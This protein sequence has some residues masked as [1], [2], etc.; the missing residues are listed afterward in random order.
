VA[1]TFFWVQLA[2]RSRHDD[3]ARTQVGTPLT[4]EADELAADELRTHWDAALAA[5]RAL[6]WTHG[7]WDLVRTDGAAADFDK[8]VADLEDTTDVPD[9][10]LS[11]KGEPHA[12]A[13]VLVQ[14][15]RDHNA[16]LALGEA[17]DLP[18]A[19]WFD[20]SVFSG[21]LDCARG[22]SLG[23]VERLAVYVQPGPGG[24]GPDEAQ[25]MQGWDHLRSIT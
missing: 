10:A 25:L 7:A 24:G 3:P 20:R 21:L 15:R 19:N 18:E 1:M 8:W 14:A 11:R 17:C 13:T 9:W 4:T 23:S 16:D 2:W 6:P 22:L 5:L 12:V